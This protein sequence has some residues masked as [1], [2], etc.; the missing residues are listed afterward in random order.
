MSFEGVLVRSTA[1]TDR[2]SGHASTPAKCQELTN[3]QT[4]WEGAAAIVVCSYCGRLEGSI[5]HGL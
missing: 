3:E 4:L 2:Q 5:S 1:K